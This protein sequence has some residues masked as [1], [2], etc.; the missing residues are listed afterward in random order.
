MGNHRLWTHRGYEASF[1][2]RFVL[3]LLSSMAAQNSIYF[4]VRDHRVHHKHSDTIADPHNVRRGFFYAHIGWL[5]FKKSP[6]VVK[7]GKDLD[8]SDLE[9]D[10]VVMFQHRFSGPMQFFLAFVVPMELTHALCGASRWDS[11]VANVVRWL[12]SV[13]LTWLVNSAA[14]S[15]GDRP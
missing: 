3:M 12:V 6:E 9:N 2:V 4:W 5:F 13:H 15:W 7:A 14:H 1:S 8:L 11:F 10:W